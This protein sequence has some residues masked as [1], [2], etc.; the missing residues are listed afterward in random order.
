MEWGSCPSPW[1]APGRQVLCAFMEQTFDWCHEKEGVSGRVWCSTRSWKGWSLN[2]HKYKLQPIENF[3]SIWF[4][5]KHYLTALFSWLYLL[6]SSH[7][8]PSRT[9]MPRWHCMKML[10]LWESIGCHRGRDSK[11]SQR[12]EISQAFVQHREIAGATCKVV[13]F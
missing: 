2:D 13:L 4:S 6:N 11:G 7:L 1:P 8:Q 5:T 3:G 10:R 9:A 12:W